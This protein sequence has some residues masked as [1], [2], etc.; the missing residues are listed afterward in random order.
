MDRQDKEIIKLTVKD[1]LFAIAGG[2][3][4][5]YSIFERNCARRSL[6]KIIN[7]NMAN[8]ADLRQKIYYLKKRKIINVVVEGKE[9]YLELTKK[10]EEKYLWE[11]IGQNKNW[12]EWDKKF[13]MVI[14]DIPENKKT[15]REIIRK[16]LVEIGFEMMQKSV[17]VFPFDCKEEIDIICYY[18]GAETYLKYI[19]ADIVQG[20]AEI[21][22]EFLE[23]GVLKDADIK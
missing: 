16:K 2:G 3:L 12:P 18:T 4:T 19:I 7:D 6:N 20:E 5:F 22:Q 8:R 21:I 9:K 13:R 14:F 1:L 17:F 10:G 11:K 15:V 23:K